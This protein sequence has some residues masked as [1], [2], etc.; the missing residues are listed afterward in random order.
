MVY[1]Y[2]YGYYYHTIMSC[3]SMYV[4]MIMYAKFKIKR[5]SKKTEQSVYEAKFSDSDF[6]SQSQSIPILPKTKGVCIVF[7]I[8]IK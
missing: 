5:E 4:M 3:R 8:I 7:L 1:G 6:F 2:V